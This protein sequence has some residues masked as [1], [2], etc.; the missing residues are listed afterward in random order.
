MVSRPRPAPVPSHLVRAAGA[1]V[2]RFRDRQRPLVTGEK[3]QAEDIDVL[4]VH[5]PKYH[6][7]S[8]PKGKSE[9]QEP[10]AQAAVREVEEET[11]Y[12]VRLWAPLTTQRYRLGTRQTKE[13]FYWVGTP[14]SDSTDTLTHDGPVPLRARRPVQHASSR[15]IDEAQWL[16]PDQAHELLTRRG[17]RRLLQELLARAQN[18]TLVTSTLALLS[19]AATIPQD[20]W[21]GTPEAL[22]L[23]R[24][25]N[26]QA[27]RIS[28]VLS[29]FGIEAALTSPQASCTA[30]LGP[31]VALSQGRVIKLAELSYEAITADASKAQQ[32]VEKLVAQP[33]IPTVVCADHECLHSLVGPLEAATLVPQRDTLQQKI[34]TY[35]FADFIVAHIAHT[36]SPEIIAREHHALRVKITPQE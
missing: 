11:G 3:I 8:W 16:S 29:A 33:H 30:T 4:L 22:P 17:D 20:L 14:L 1:L 23:S 27:L 26:Y 36:D 10:L 19:N 34:L 24:L 21:E 9:S 13:V 35:T 12:A 5:R 6:D 18:G 28:D 31:W 15:E 7:W 2:W 25:G 32:V